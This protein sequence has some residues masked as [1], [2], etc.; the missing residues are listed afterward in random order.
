MRRL[1]FY[2]ILQCVAIVAVAQNPYSEVL[3]LI[4]RNNPMLNSARAEAEYA[5]MEA[6]TGLAPENPEVEFG[7]MF[8]SPGEIGDR[9]DVSVSQSFDFPTVYGKKRRLADA[10]QQSTKALFSEQR[11]NVLLE[12]KSVCVNLIYQRMVRTLYA[13]QYERAL[14][15][16]KALAKLDSVGQTMAIEVNKNR[17][18][19]ADLENQ[20][21]QT[22]REIDALEASLTALNGGE[23]ILF[24]ADRF[25]DTV[26]PADFE[27][28]FS[29]HSSR[30]P[31]INVANSEISIADRTIGVERSL[32]LPKLSVGYSGEFVP[33]ESYQGI[34]LGVSI[35]LWENRNKV[36]AARLRLNAAELHRQD[37]EISARAQYKRTY[38]NAVMLYRNAERL[39]TEL[40][41]CNNETLLF[42]ALSM[43]QINQLTYLL[44]LDYF[45]EMY[46]KYLDT[47][48]DLNLEEAKLTAPLL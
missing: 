5:F 18:R 28:W 34:T 39:K 44:E 6:R 48:R 13:G 26:L 29:E 24:S 16:G 1:L 33:G 38:D 7:Y 32:N 35:P 40:D 2:M 8:G 21:S 4:E 17:V 15:I 31:E 47:V 11:M 23:P 45:N 46:I 37:V 19:L 30:L 27:A 14:E 12:A 41:D 10:Q 9:K 36:K 20:L 42:K 22:D 43:G 3:N 25:G